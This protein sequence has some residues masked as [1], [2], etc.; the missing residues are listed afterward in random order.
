MGYDMIMVETPGDGFDGYLRL[1][2]WGMGNAREIMT[3]FGMITWEHQARSWN[4]ARNV[5]PTNHD[6]GEGPIPGYKFCSND[7]W[8][9]TERECSEAIEA[10]ESFD[11]Q[12]RQ[13]IA[14]ENPWFARFVEY[15]EV[16]SRN[17]G[18]K[19]W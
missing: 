19:V 13:G 5:D 4:S 2:I 11:E 7:G 8:H 10:W 14:E 1:N 16:A 12:A 15:I 17:G 9:V 3:D 18:F 6:H